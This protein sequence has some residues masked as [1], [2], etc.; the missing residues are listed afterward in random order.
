MDTNIV[1]TNL[2]DVCGHYK[3]FSVENQGLKN[4]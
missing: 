4:I 1:L 3:I 2:N